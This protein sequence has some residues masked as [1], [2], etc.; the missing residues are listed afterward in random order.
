MDVEDSILLVDDEPNVI[1]SLKRA[2][3]DEP[4]DIYSAGSAR[5]G[6]KV[7]E[8]SRIKVIVSDERMPGMTGAEFLSAV[9]ERNPETLRIM[10]TG[11]A[12]IEAAMTA[13]NSGEIYRFFVK[14]WNDV[15]LKLA[16]RSALEK[17]NLEAE[18]RRLLR[19]VRRQAVDLKLLERKYPSITKLDKDERGNLILPDM[20]E[21]EFSEILAECEREF[22]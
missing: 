7:L 2:L 21:T 22:S 15:E 16:I 5:E 13:V 19:I 18:N 17:Y 1:S 14:P 10:L 4:Y 6:L 20:S 8:Q 3:M 12:S 11:H 9:K